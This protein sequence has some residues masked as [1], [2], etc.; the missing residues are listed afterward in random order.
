MAAEKGNDGGVRELKKLEEAR[1]L[2]DMA[3]E[4][5]KAMVHMSVMDA[6]AERTTQVDQDKACEEG[7]CS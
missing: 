3:K 2:G 6:K 1:N 5:T 7:W 4:L